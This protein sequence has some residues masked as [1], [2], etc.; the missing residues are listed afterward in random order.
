M[1]TA[2]TIDVF[3]GSPSGVD[4]STIGI[5]VCRNGV[6][7]TASG[8]DGVCDSAADPAYGANGFGINGCG[9]ANWFA[10]AAEDARKTIWY[11]HNWRVPDIA[12]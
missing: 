8:S 11:L 7:L 1:F 12:Y 4:L 6:P 9:G 2:T 3:G 10:Q 5:T